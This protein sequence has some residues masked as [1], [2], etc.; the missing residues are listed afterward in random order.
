MRTALLALVLSLI[1]GC[2][3]PSRWN[4]FR[5]PANSGIADG[6]PIPAS[7][8]KTENVVWS[9]EI[10]GSGWSSPVIWG[11]QV[12]VTSAITDF[13]AKQPSPGLFGNDD[14][15]ELIKQ[16]VSPA[17][18]GRRI[19]ERDIETT[20]QPAQIVRY[21]VYCLDVK[22]GGILWEQKAH[23]GV[24]PGGRHRKNTYA[25]A[26]PVTDGQ[27]VYAF[28]G[29]VGLFCFDMA[30]KPLWSQL[31]TPGKIYLD[32]GTGSSPALCDDKVIILNDNDTESIIAAYDAASGR[33]LWKNKREVRSG[34][35]TPFVWRTTQRT[36]IVAAGGP[37]ILS[38]SPDGQELWR[39]ALRNTVA[40]TP[41]AS[42]HMLFVGVGSVNEP[43]Q[44]LL[45]IRLGGSGDISPTSGE[46]KSEFVAWRNTKAGPYIPSPIYYRG[47][48]Y[49]AY[50][51]GFIAAFDAGTGERLYRE[52]IGEGGVSITASPLAADGKLYVLDEDGT[53]H[54]FEAGDAHKPLGQ[55]KLEEFSMS[56]PAATP[57]G[58]FVRTQSRLYRIRA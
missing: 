19:L 49:V 1:T 37:W 8:S 51:K 47:R 22:S 21:M 31:I 2:T 25:S 10:P 55:C 32:F 56:S 11:D 26:T 58:L 35:S 45:A 48:I 46:D 3:T 12:F 33:E 14:I 44:P 52:R 17:E 27:R 13:D 24:P 38:Y 5:G 29:N 15:E 57:A 28:F 39:C 41:I 30:G 9:T 34:W 53:M 40:T 43:Q 7:W 42:E 54:I 6:A 4:Q 18:A 20:S 23:E 50:D 36:E 16:G